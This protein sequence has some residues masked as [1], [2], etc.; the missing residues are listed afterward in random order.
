[1]KS[2]LNLTLIVFSAAVVALTG[3]KK[4]AVSPTADGEL[5]ITAVTKQIGTSF[6]K[7]FTGQ[8]GGANIGDGITVP[9]N[10]KSTRG[11]RVNSI[12]PYCGYQIDTTDNVSYQ[13]FDT[14]KNI[15]SKYKFIYTCSADNL[16]GYVLTDT[17]TY[18]DNGPL[19]TNKYLI[20]QNYIVSKADAHYTMVSMK[21]TM[22]NNFVKKVLNA[23]GSVI[24]TKNNHTEYTLTNVKIKTAGG[25]ADISSG[26]VTFEASLSEETG[27]KT[28]S[29]NFSGSMTFLGNKKA[30]IKITYKNKTQK[31]SLDLA[32]YDQTQIFD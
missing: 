28:F 2:T 17:V 23:E 9:N 21:G 5:D 18:T 25:S 1:M 31:Y 27:G 11:P 29:G 15:D 4:G 32:T 24:D 26:T 12:E 20:A 6:Y 8:Y 22:G 13:A 14:L 3:C 30:N 16:D 19:F 10:V 7:S